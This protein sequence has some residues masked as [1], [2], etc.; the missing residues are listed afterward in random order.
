MALSHAH[1]KGTEKCLKRVNGGTE[2]GAG[3]RL[4]FFSMYVDEERENEGG[5]E[6]GGEEEEEENG[7]MHRVRLL[8]KKGKAGEGGRT[9]C[10]DG[11]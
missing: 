8:A 5:R 2:G 9:G 10:F 7:N 11:W 3:G 6:G 1:G 4:M